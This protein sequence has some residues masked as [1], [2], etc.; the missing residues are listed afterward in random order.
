[1]EDSIQV[2]TDQFALLNSLSSLSSDENQ[3]FSLWLSNGDALKVEQVVRRV[4]NK[5]L[6]CQAV[7]KEQAVYAK[8]FIGNGAK[9]YAQ[10]DKQG[11]DALIAANIAL[12]KYCLLTR[13]MI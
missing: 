9:R 2:M 7:W 12:Q 10:R 3:A 11:V 6:V 13:L 1:M 5:R 8:L 4:P